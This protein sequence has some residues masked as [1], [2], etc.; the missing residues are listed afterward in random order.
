MQISAIIKQM[1]VLFL[2]LSVGYSANKLKVM[3]GASNSLLSKMVMNITMPCTILSSVMSGEVTMTENEALFF[4]L[5][6]LCTFVIASILII[7]VPYLIKAPAADKGLYRFL[8]AF[9]NVGFMG[10]P[11]TYSIFGQASVFYVALFNIPF[12][13]IAFSV[14][15]VMVAGKKG[16]IDLKL[17]INPSLIASIATIMLFALKIETPVVIAETAD[18]LGRVTTPAAMLIIGSTLASIPVKKVF[19]QWR[20]YPVTLLKLIVV[21]IITWAVLRLFIRND[22]MLGILVVLSGMPTATAAT[23]IALEY[24]GN[25]RLASTGVFITTL[26]SV[27]TIPALMFLLFT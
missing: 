17:F 23:M 9:G 27:V 18:L 5:M 15:I 12:T 22:L 2:V 7:P 16:R 14:G 21:P 3:S 4:G 10:F 24:G 19:S 8:I 25:D 20:L 11:V 6:I 26:F 1:T 13:I